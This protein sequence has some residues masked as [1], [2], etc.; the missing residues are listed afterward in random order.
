MVTASFLY[1]L[2]LLNLVDCISLSWI[3]GVRI[4]RWAKVNFNLGDIVTSMIKC[5][6]GQTIIVTHDTNSPRPY[7]LGFRVQELRFM[8]E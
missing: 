6:N 3:M 5:S 7:S 1:P 8:D 2:W 4:I